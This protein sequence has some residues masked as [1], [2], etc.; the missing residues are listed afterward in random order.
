MR[1]EIEKVDSIKCNLKITVEGEELK[2]KRNKVYTEVGKSL[3]VPGFRPGSA[4]LEILEKRYA[5]KLKDE[6]IKEAIPFYYQKAVE[7]KGLK[8]VCLPNFYNVKLSG[9]ELFFCVSLEIEP[10]V[11]FPEKVYKGIKI[12]DYALSNCDKEVEETIN[13]IKEEILKIKKDIPEELLPRWLG[14]KDYSFLKE[15]ISA[16]IFMDKL[17]KRKEFIHQQII[18]HLDKNI[19]FPLPASQIENYA[20]QI[21]NKDIYA[22]R[23]HNCSEEEIERYKEQ[24][25]EE[26][27]EIARVQVKLYYIFRHIAEKENLPRDKE[28]QDSVLGFILTYACYE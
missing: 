9:N 7:E 24:K 12:K 10:Q 3:K 2:E 21:L 18:Q 5:E 23:L 25:K 27:K 6:F 28:V 8:P 11:S 14:Y 1:I 15:A 17:E 26:I 19:K 22:L 16:R 20:Q 13:K 4:P